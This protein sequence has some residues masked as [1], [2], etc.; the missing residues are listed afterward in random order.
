MTYTI[1]AI[2][3]TYAGINF[4]SRLEAKWAAFFDLMSW[5]WSYEP[6]DFDGWIPDFILHGRKER[7][8][9]EVKPLYEADE[10][11]FNE[12]SK[13]AVEGGSSDDILVLG[14][15]LP[16]HIYWPG[17]GV[18]WLGEYL[19]DIHID[20]ENQ[21]V[22]GGHEWGVAPVH[23]GGGAIG[24]CHETMSYRNRIS[25]F[26]DGDSG[27]GDG[28]CVPYIRAMWKEAGNIIQWKSK[29]EAA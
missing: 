8:L 15:D 13:Q 1:K 4:R 25:G 27:A 14:A 18:G 5:R 24:F 20:V 10:R 7:I 26:Y 28:G 16:K 21:R 12:V 2:P 9:V 23:S 19:Q 3:T 11:L 17:V 6:I 22:V 29:R